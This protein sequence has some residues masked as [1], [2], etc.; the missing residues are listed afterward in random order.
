MFAHSYMFSFSINFYHSPRKSHSSTP[1]G[2]QSH[3]NSHTMII[4]LKRKV[5]CKKLNFLNLC[6]KAVYHASKNLKSYSGEA[7]GYGNQIH[8]I[9]FGT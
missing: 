9:F 3:L 6:N 4:G 1:R 7:P 5:Y 8:R 2:D